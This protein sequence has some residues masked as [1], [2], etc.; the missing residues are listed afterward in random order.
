MKC[1]NCGQAELRAQRGVY[2]YDLAGLPYPIVLVGV[3]FDVCPACGER[4]VTIPDPEGLHRLLALHIVEA[5]R[6]LLGQELR[7][8]RKFLGKSAEDMTALLGVDTK[9]LSRWEN[10]RQKM[11]KVAERLLRL[12]VHQKLVPEASTFAEDVFPGLQE[13]GEAVAVTFTASEGG[14]KEAA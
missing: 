3:P 10:G 8:L 7:F 4:A 5:D 9:T 13:E 2:E 14:W 1:Y 6:P 12:L 11:G